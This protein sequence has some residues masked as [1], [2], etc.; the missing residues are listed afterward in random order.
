MPIVE[1][2]ILVCTNDRWLDYQR[3]L[4]ITRVAPGRIYGRWSGDEYESS[5]REDEIR[6]NFENYYN[7]R[8]MR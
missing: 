1:G 6:D 4:T 2:D 8:G 5:F 7:K 3:L